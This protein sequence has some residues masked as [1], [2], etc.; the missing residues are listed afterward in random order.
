MTQQRPRGT[1]RPT[2]DVARRAAYDVLHEVGSSDAYANLALSAIQRS[3]E[4]SIR[5][6]GFCTEVVNGT[7]RYRGLLHAAITE[8][9]GRPTDKLDPRVLD[10]LRM[11]TYQLLL[12][13][14]DAYA[15]VDTSVNLVRSVAGEAP[16]GLVNAVLRKV[17][18]KTREQWLQKVSTGPSG[19][20]AQLAVQLSHPEWIVSALRDSLGPNQADQ[21]PAL[22][23]AN[24]DP[25]SVTLAA[26]P[27]LST[28]DDLVAAGASPG[29]WSPFAAIAPKGPVGSFPPVRDRRAGV[30]DEGSQLVTAALANATVEGSD[31]TWVDLCAGPGGKLALLS[32]LGS[33]RG[34]LT[35][36]VELHPHRAALIVNSV[37][38]VPGFAGVVV[39]DSRQAP[40]RPGVDRV[41]LDVPCT[42]LGVVRR[43]P[44]LRW[45][46]TPSDV[47][48]LK[49]LQTQLLTAAL[50]LVRPGGVVAYVTCSP[51][52]AETEIV[53]SSVTRRREDV[54]V[55]DSRPLFPGVPDLG[56]GPNVR[57]WPHLHGTDGMF[58]SLMR[59]R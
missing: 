50:D 18:T 47:P 15:A 10:V 9:S 51:H 2:V 29:R 22:L 40:I 38:R 44:E 59:R 24:N 54:V 48:A 11:G 21:L 32:A 12:M 46:R 1:R 4:L 19:S 39:G 55:E 37:A 3:Q 34:A 45:R 41:L 17:G 56:Q 35:V 52:I 25:P 30:Q 42:G 57:L 16:A 53:V 26:R 43:R 27:G 20:D 23:A 5:D 33:P 14:T 58:F 31:R 6:A 28:V 8:C 36:G 13:D 49:K 7:R